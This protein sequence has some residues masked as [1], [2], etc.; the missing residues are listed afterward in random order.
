M[1]DCWL[2]LLQRYRAIAVVRSPQWELGY[3]MAAAVARSGMGLIEITWNTDRAGELIAALRADFPHLTIGTGTILTLEDLEN[4]LSAGA[5]FIFTPHVSAN[6]IQAATDAGVPIVPGAL[7][8]TEIVTAWQLG[9]SCVKVFPISAVGGA[10]YLQSLRGPL[11]NIPLI[12]TGGVT[13][14]NAPELL[15]AGAVAV[16]LAGDLFP[17]ELLAA[18][19]WDGVAYRC[20]LLHQRLTR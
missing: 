16:G 5:Q 4:A 1:R 15:A 17:K 14:E 19:N 9:A 20:H 10:S 8:P 11:G 12:P 13:G 3:H 6:L 7:S 18:G 2:N